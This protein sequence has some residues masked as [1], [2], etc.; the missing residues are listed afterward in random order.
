MTNDEG[1][2]CMCCMPNEKPHAC[3]YTDG[4]IARVDLLE[5]RIEEV[6]TI[7]CRVAKAFEDMPRTLPAPKEVMR[8]ER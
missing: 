4:Q 8:D 7:L 3:R 1:C 2:T 5:Q 6:W